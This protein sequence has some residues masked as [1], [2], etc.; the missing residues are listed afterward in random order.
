MQSQRGYDQQNLSDQIQPNRIPPMSPPSFDEYSE[1]SFP[2]HP[3]PQLQSNNQLALLDHS[4]ANLPKVGE[5]RCCTS[6]SFLPPQRSS[7]R[8]TSLTSLLDWALLSSD[9]HF[10]Y[11]DPVLTSHLAEQA[12]ALIGKSLLVFVH[13]DEQ[14]SAKHDLGSVLESRTLHGSVTRY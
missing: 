2:S 7:F 8:S 4:N 1:Q 6:Q 9:L 10:I 3:S 12:D 11:T 14:A 5:T 13:P